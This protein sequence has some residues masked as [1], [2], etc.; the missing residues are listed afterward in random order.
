MAWVVLL[1]SAAAVVIVGAVA[2]IL[3]LSDLTGP[4]VV[5]GPGLFVRFVAA[6]ALTVVSLGLRSLRWI[7]LL[8][9]AGT[10]IPIRDAYIGYFAGLSL[11]LV[12]L[13][14]G[15]ISV[16]SLVLRAR[17]AVPIS[18]TV[19]VSIWER[20]SDLV[21]IGLIA[22]S[23]SIALEGSSTWN[24]LLIAAIAI[25]T[26][27][28]VRRGLLN[29]VA[30]ASRR[31]AALFEAPDR[32]DVTRL[33]GNRA[34]FSVIVTSLVAWLLPG[35]G[36]WLIA[37]TWGDQFSLARA[38]LTYAVS[39]GIGGVEGA[40]GGVIVAG[41]H[42]L[43]AFASAGFTPA[44]AA[45]V[46]LAIRMAT[47]GVAT[48]LG[49]VFVAMHVWSPRSELATHFD[50]IADAYDVQIPEARR[51]ALLDRKTALMREILQQ[52]GSGRIGLDVGCG[53]GAYV[54]RMRALGFDVNGIDASPGQVALAARRFSVSG[55]VSLGSVLDIPAKDASCD[56]VYIINVLHHLANVDEQRRA[57]AELLRVLRPGGVLFVHEIN[58]RNLLFRFHMGYVFPSLNC[59]DEGVERWLL[60]D[61]LAMYTDAAVTEVRYFTFLPEFLAPGFVKLLASLER[62]LEGSS[63]R[64]Y[65][66][67]YMAVIRKP[68]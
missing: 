31:A 27:K 65:S 49:L 4:A 13:L 40:P 42:F 37:G 57:F 61:Q 62:W 66:A 51:L 68:A 35:V 43:S 24:L 8:R 54:E 19:L 16:R 34:W 26:V 6:S 50:A 3:A 30:A 14:L 44:K 55:V 23:V 47:L 46:V 67:H 9:R 10:R 41:G 17:G 60:P 12:P 28:P 15:E 33:S 32:P 53:Q 22:A 2:T 21:A 39:T 63:L 11:L 52:L 58:T 56:F 64:V 38:E 29:V 25:T 1:A 20:F 36:L 18:T 59:I 7:F 48:V 45:L 5:V